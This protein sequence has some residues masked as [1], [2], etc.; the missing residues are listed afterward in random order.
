MVMAVV[1]EEARKAKEQM[2]QNAVLEYMAAITSIL[3]GDWGSVGKHIENG[4]MFLKDMKNI[5]ENKERIAKQSLD[6]AEEGLRKDYGTQSYSFYGDTPFGGAVAS[7][8]SAGMK[9]VNHGS[10]Q[11]SIT[12]HTSSST[13]LSNSYSDATSA[14]QKSLDNA[15]QAL[16]EDYGAQDNENHISLIGKALNFAANLHPAVGL[17][18]SLFGDDNTE[19]AAADSSQPVINKYEININTININTEDDPEKIKT[20]FMDLMIEMSEQVTPRY[21]SRTTGQVSN[22]QEQSTGTQVNYNNNN[23]NST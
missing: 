9:V 6:I 16:H 22:T 13:S 17:I 2:F 5:D 23:P 10:S 4:D 12:G 11:T 21:V 19:S 3:N 15:A 14:A 7:A 18:K 1:E 20:A 8:K